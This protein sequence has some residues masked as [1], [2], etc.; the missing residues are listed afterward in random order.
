[1]GSL[2]LAAHMG[3]ALAFDPEKVFKPDEPPR[4]ILRYG[5][6][7]LKSGRHEDA[8]G[9]FRYGAVKNH[10]PAQWKLARMLQTGQG[11]EKDHFAAFKMYMKI[12]QRFAE[13]M[14]ARG[15]LPYVA[16][17]VVTL[18]IYLENGIEG[19]PVRANP[20]RAENFYYRA[21]AI[22]RDAEAQ[23][24]LGRLYLSGELGTPRPRMAARWF[25]SATK[26]GHA[27][28]QAELGRMMFYG[29]GVRRNR[30]KGL[31]HLTRAKT[32]SAAQG[33]SAIVQMEEEAYAVADEGQRSAA[34][35]II[36]R[37]T[38]KNSQ[39]AQPSRLGFGSDTA[40]SE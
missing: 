6:E 39:P 24:R 34:A 17:A 36:E 40:I 14:P 37:L 4:T 10:V 7:A 28:A 16:H 22:Y 32:R 25:S 38:P 30:V 3:Q 18:G 19:S 35:R 21:S 27:L 13:N 11:V 8:L 23:Y 29:E 33:L 2:T 20:R 15:D 26:K 31:V 1:M 9:A 12:A 5:F